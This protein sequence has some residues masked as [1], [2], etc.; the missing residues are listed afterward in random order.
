MIVPSNM[1]QDSHG[2]HDSGYHD[3]NWSHMHSYNPSPMSAFE[4]EY[5]SQSGGQ[6]LSMESFN[7][8]MAPPPPPAL[9]P[10]P[11]NVYS[12]QLPRG[13]LIPS[14][15][16]SQVPWPS[17]Q[18]NP[19]RSFGTPPIP[20][21][22]ASAPPRI[23]QTKLPSTAT[24]GPRKTLTIEDRR[25]MCKYAEENPHVKQTEIGA[26]FGVERR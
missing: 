5:Y 1:D 19:S 14:H 26:R 11:Q 16:T 12:T 15:Q 10:Q 17:L 20:I 18:T 21:P 23:A 8:Q 22:P 9:R 3:G 25:A 7:M 4:S 6:P 24:T 13:L 2:D